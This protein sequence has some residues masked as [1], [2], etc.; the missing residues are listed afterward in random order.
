[1]GPLP[2]SKA[3]NQFLTTMMCDSTL[4]PEAIP[5]RKITVPVIT[6]D[7]VK[8]F[9]PFGLPKTVQTD[10]GTN[11]KSKVFAK[12]LKTLSITHVMSSPYHPE[13]QGALEKFHQTMK[14]KLRNSVMNHRR[15][16]MKVFHLFYLQPEKL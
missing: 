1:M 12:V 9:T 15:I 11:F 8:F 10:Q 4:F 5:L 3:R 2:K 7:L 16:G 13:S 6:K 14:S